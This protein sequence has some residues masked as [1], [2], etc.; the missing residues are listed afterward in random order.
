MYSGKPYKNDAGNEGQKN[1][2][3]FVELASALAILD[4]LEMPDRELESVDGKAL[5]PVYKEFG[6]KTDSPD[7]K[8][9]DF[10]DNTE[11]KISLRLS[12]LAMFRKY[13]DER[14][15]DAIEKQAWSNDAPTIDRAFL[16]D[17]FYRTNLSEFMTSFGD[18]LKEMSGNRRG[19]TP[20]NLSSTLDSLV[21]DKLVKTGWLEKKVD[22][23]FYDDNLSKQSKGKNFPSAEQKMIKLFFDTTEDMLTSKFGFKK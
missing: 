3:H 17:S 20:F 6:M 14:I 11:Y 9:S 15:G 2:A 21:V 19:F 10:E 18:W 7:F 12:Q 13:L 23:P 8:F 4:F 22:Y 1:D 5:K 16:S